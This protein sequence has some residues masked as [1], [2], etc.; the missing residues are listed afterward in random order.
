[1]GAKGWWAQL[2]AGSTQIEALPD[3]QLPARVAEPRS[4]EALRLE[5][6]LLGVLQPRVGL[7]DSQ[8]LRAHD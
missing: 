7:A 2:L 1:M 8:L 3:T 6:Q 5:A 4:L